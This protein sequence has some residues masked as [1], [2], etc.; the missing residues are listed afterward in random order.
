MTEPNAVMQGLG[1]GEMSLGLSI[2]L[3]RG[4]E[5]VAAAKAAGFD[6][7]FI[8]LEHGP[9]SFDQAAQM[10]LAGLQICI[11]P[12][13]RVPGHD[14]APAGRALT[15]GALGLFFPHVDTVAHA[16]ACAAAA[17]FA[18]LGVRGVP[19]FFPQIGL[20]KPP[21][22]EAIPRLNA[23]TTVIAMIESD[24]AVAN[25]DAIAATPGVDLLF[26]G[27]SDLTVEQA[28]PG[29][30]DHPDTLA[31]FA[32]VAR[33]C[34][35]HGKVAGLGGVPA[36]PLLDRLIAQGYRFILAG[37]D[38]DLMIGAGRERAGQLR[39]AGRRGG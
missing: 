30:Y 9:Y 31:A 19:A 24:E 35:A 15:N 23:M 38:L 26:V 12:F 29:A 7:L 11:A 2:R 6:W 8:D 13:V 16:R 28:R 37:N 5:A 10:M 36:G 3:G 34:A 21:L 22:A 32:R 4:I 20:P 17:R 33:A 1:R 18:P 14:P 39:A 27:A 25:A